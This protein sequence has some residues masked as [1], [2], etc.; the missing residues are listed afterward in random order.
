M[1]HNIIR[2]YKVITFKHRT[3]VTKEGRPRGGGGGGG[4]GGR[5]G[6]GRG[7]AETPF[8][9][10]ARKRGVNL[11]AEEER[12]KDQL[13]KGQRVGG[14]TPSSQRGIA[15]AGGG[16]GATPGG[17]EFLK[18]NLAAAPLTFGLSS[19]RRNLNILN[20]IPLVAAAKIL[21]SQQFKKPDNLKDISAF[22]AMAL[23]TGVTM[24]AGQ[25]ARA[26]VGLFSKELVGLT[27]AKGTAL[28]SNPTTIR[29]IQKM[30]VKQSS[31][32]SWKKIGAWM[33]GA[34]IVKEILQL[35]L[36]GK[37]FG[38]FL[39]VEEASQT[40]G[41]ATRD[42][43]IRGNLDAYEEGAA[44]RD[45]VLAED[46]FWEGLISYI[47]YLN[48]GRKLETYRKTGISA[49]SIH[50]QIAEDMRLELEGETEDQKFARIRQLEID[51]QK[52]I[53]D[54]WAITQRATADYEAALIA[55]GQKANRKEEKKAYR[56]AADFWAAERARERE[57][58]AADRLAIAEFWIA[59][60]KE[61][62][63]IA[64]ESRPSN[65]N[66]GLL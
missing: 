63:R 54:N 6:G 23:I 31:K 1:N 48:V 40:I 55:A 33:L 39:G 32:I 4:G 29:M 34:V 38:E 50:D 17:E 11:R 46:D 58:E 51:Q 5:G 12:A 59:Y 62:A 2:C 61:A 25:T 16:K 27:G 10:L 43:L 24:P 26:G 52:T 56:E 20:E 45:E 8:Q 21:L 41:I 22:D 66:F 47:P 42:A 9:K 65:L 28:S 37:N 36:G 53:A 7:K 19:G 57:R 15:A 18:L 64:A 13:A 14:T 60:R 49:A 3:D 44:V 30:A 35:T